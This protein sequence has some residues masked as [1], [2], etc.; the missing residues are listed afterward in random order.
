MQHYMCGMSMDKC[1][2]LVA[3]K[4]KEGNKERKA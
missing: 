2:Y 3:G 4:Q 1:V